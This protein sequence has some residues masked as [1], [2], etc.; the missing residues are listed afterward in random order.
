MLIR[1]AKL[2]QIQRKGGGKVIYQ[3]LHL[4]K[5]A[6]SHQS[7]MYVCFENYSSHGYGKEKK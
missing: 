5:S 7:F 3:K 4:L 2:L 6:A 1:A